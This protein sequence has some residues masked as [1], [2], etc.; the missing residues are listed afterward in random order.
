MVNYGPIRDNIKSA[1]VIDKIKMRLNYDV[2]LSRVR[3][4]GAWTPQETGPW[5]VDPPGYGSVRRGPP[6]RRVRAA[7]TPLETGPW[8]VVP[9]VK[10][11]KCPFKLLT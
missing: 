6:W 10:S 7:W 8:G 9:H 11:L 4:R 3:V 1:T 2:F 5:G